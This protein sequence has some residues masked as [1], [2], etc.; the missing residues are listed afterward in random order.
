MSFVKKP[1]VTAK[2][3]LGEAAPAIPSKAWQNAAGQKETGVRLGRLPS[4]LSLGD[5][6]GEPIYYDVARKTL[7]YRGF[8]CQASYKYLRKLSLDLDYKTAIDQLYTG[9]A[10][11]DSPRNWR[12]VVLAAVALA[13]A[14]GAWLV[15]HW[16][17]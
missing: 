10:V 16:L 15:W 17:H 2:Q 6:V 11:D 13:V 14:A 7:V 8:M 1:V 5:E 12:W 4:G 9:S 3:D